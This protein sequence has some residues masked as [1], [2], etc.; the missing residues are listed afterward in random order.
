MRLCP[1]S[2]FSERTQ[3]IKWRSARHL[4]LSLSR[5]FLEIFYNTGAV[6]FRG[7]CHTLTFVCIYI[8]IC[9]SGRMPHS[10]RWQFLSVIYSKTIIQICDR[11]RLHA[12]FQ[13]PETHGGRLG[14][15]NVNRTHAVE[16]LFLFKE[17]EGCVWHFSPR[18]QVILCGRLWKL[19]C[20]T[21]VD[22]GFAFWA[23]CLV[24]PF[25]ELYGAFLKL[26]KGW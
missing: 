26:E 13:L 20:V 6:F 3:R 9:Y 8:C 18:D 17:L 1:E 4:N 19:L 10:Q 14:R 25:I 23:F 21:S 7:P 15:Q 22:I 12:Y 2:R 24:N 5:E 11:A 16:Y